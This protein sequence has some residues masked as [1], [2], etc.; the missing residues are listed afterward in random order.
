MAFKV[1]LGLLATLAASSVSSA[2]PSPKKMT[3]LQCNFDKFTKFDSGGEPLPIPVNITRGYGF[4]SN[5]PAM[6]DVY[7]PRS[8]L[9]AVVVADNV[10]EFRSTN[11]FDAIGLYNESEP[12]GKI[13]TADSYSG[14]INRLTGWV[15][16]TFYPKYGPP[17]IAACKQR[18]NAFW[19]NSLPV[20]AILSGNCHAVSR[21]F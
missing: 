21:R 9:Q 3:Y 1:W 13:D 14:T 12:N 18:K 8:A 4:R 11:I 10:I 17:E 19:C 20:T 7:F 2:Q 15:K 16:I 6:V 5:P